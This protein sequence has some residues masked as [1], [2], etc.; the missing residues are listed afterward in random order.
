M[1]NTYNE[2]Y[3]C[4]NNFLQ[5]KDVKAFKKL[6]KDSAHVEFNINWETNTDGRHTYDIMNKVEKQYF[7]SLF[8]SK[9]TEVFYY[10]L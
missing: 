2:F 9:E 10:R 8:I 4:N 5:T 1:Q 6:L 3:E 7:S